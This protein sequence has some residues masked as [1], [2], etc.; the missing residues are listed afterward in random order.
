MSAAKDL[1]AGGAGGGE[2]EPL[3][4]RVIAELS[5]KA[6]LPRR[7]AEE[8]KAASRRVVARLLSREP[9]PGTKEAPGILLEAIV[10]RSLDPARAAIR[11][12]LVRA[13]LDEL[14][15]AVDLNRRI[16]VLRLLALAGGEESAA[17]LAEVLRSADEP[18]REY[19]LR[20]LEANPSRAAGRALVASLESAGSESDRI[21]LAN[22]LGRRRE[23]D[24]AAVLAVLAAGGGPAAAAALDALGSIGTPEAARALVE[25]LARVPDGLRTAAEAAALACAGR[26]LEAGRREAAAEALAVV[27][28]RTAIPLHRTAALRGLARAGS[29]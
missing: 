6:E 11:E 24:A 25:A 19:S 26:L 10:H 14:A 23:A 9:L 18:V 2:E 4:D 8:W 21:A 22:A 17:P 16:P 15:A 27:R 1:R 5:G 3:D 28:D 7:T 12:A 20:A 13:L 29:I